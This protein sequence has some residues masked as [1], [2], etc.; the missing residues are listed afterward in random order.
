[1]TSSPY[2]ISADALA[3]QLDQN[4]PL[5]IISSCKPQVHKQVSIA[6]AIFLHGSELTQ[7]VGDAT[8]MLPDTDSLAS[9]LAARGISK[10]KPTV[11][12]DDEGGG[13][14]ARVLWTLEILGFENLTL[15]DG[16]LHAWMASGNEL[17]SGTTEYTPIS[18][19]TF[20]LNTLPRTTLTDVKSRLDDENT[21][22]WDCR[23]LA[24]YTGDQL[25]AKRGGHIPH[26]KHYEWTSPMNREQKLVLRPLDDI[27]N[28]LAAL[29]ITAE[30][31]IITYCQS[32][33]R[34]SFTYWLGKILGLNIRAYDGAWSEWGNRHDTP[35]ETGS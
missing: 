6:G 24:E 3:A 25:T 10:D 1:M 34:S 26:A 16:G 19:E 18:P 12:Y 23:S 21:V 35:V 32:H 27:K 7:T 13:W 17:V 11:V 30:K 9:L 15:L 31:Q 28:E 5:Q 33:H 20:T 29:G 4:A 14:A 22:L 8:G 2:L